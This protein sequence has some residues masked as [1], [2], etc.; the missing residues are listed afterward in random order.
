MQ[1]R[2][3]RNTSSILLFTMA[4]AFFLA[5][6]GCARRAYR[7]ANLPPD[8]MAPAPL[9]L[10][11]LNLSNLT[12]QSISS[13]VIQPGDVLDVTIITDFTKLKTTTSPARV[14]DDGTVVVPL[15][16]RVGIS[17]LEVK[18]AEQLINTQSIA[19]GIFRNPSITVTMKK[20]HTYKVTVV[21]AVNNPGTHVLPRGSTSLMAALL[22]SGG[23]ADDAGTEVEIRHT[24]SREIARLMSQPQNL[25]GG[26]NG[27]A[28]P[29]SY[30]HPTPMIQRVDLLKATN[31]MTKLPNLSDGD[32][33][34]VS[35]RKLQ[36]VHVIGLVQ[37]PDEFEYP[38]DQQLR[39]L[40]ALALAGGCSSP[41]AEKVLVIRQSPNGGEPIR[42]E[43]SIQEAKNG[44]DNLA[45][46]PGDIV[47]V[48][49][50]AATA[51][52]DI[53]KTFFRVSMGGTLSWF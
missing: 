48:E 14:A 52:A 10:D 5:Y 34:H 12:E 2:Y 16:G 26:P 1:H 13:D 49:Q 47:S 46:A 7:V 3:S 43:V 32:V 25:P 53:I 20:C 39:V 28:T 40:D 4:F 23:L 29:V 24:D 42:I 35:R 44:R 31:G 9:D 50:T 38:P 45:L 21:G 37:K 27:L 33:V 22:A 15:V 36:P 41:V 8:L 30:E 11:S 17:G 19:R 51:A 6:G 18:Q